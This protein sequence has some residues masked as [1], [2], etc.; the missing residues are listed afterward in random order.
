VNFGERAIE[1][2][3][4]DL[5]NEFGAVIDTVFTDANGVYAFTDLSSGKYYL[6]EHQPAGYAQGTNSVGTLGGSIAAVDRFFIDL[7]ATCEADGANYNYAE[8]PTAGGAVQQGQAATI[9]F[10]QNKNGQALIKSLN[11]GSSATQ[12]GSWLAATF[13]N[14]YGADAG[15]NNLA[16]K[17]NAE[18]AGFYTT[19][20]K[21]NGQTSPGGPPKLDA[22][23]F[24]TTL[25][26]YVTNQTLAGTTA[27]SYGFQVTA[28]GLG[29]TLF[30][31]GNNGAAFG[32]ANGDSIAVID[33]LLA[34]NARTRNG[35]LFDD[36]DS[37]GTI[38]ALERQFREMADQVFRGINEQ[39]D[40]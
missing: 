3:R 33:L 16:G 35:L 1:G 21:R 15:P 5:A 29:Y 22:Q 24:A 38:D 34:V 17:T 36:T 2:V 30:N 37:P 39:G 27:A 7:S 19:L 4:I 14:M 9:G 31:V 13:P 11:G 28:N 6:Q 25:A 18:V 10:W 12:L 26:V 8:R 20:F 32:V 40:I 23:V